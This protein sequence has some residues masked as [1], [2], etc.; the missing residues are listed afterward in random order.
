[1]TKKNKSIIGQSMTIV[2]EVRCGGELII[3][4]K[5]EGV[6]DGTTVVVGESGQ[7]IGNIAADEIECSGHVEG[8][9]VSDKFIVRKGGCHLGT[10]ETREIKVDPGATL[11]CVLQSG[12]PRI[13]EPSNPGIDFNRMLSVFDDRERSCTMD[14]PWS[15]RKKLLDQLL[16]LLE[17][18][19]QLIKIT[20]ENGSGKTTFIAKLA[21]S[22]PADITPITISGPVGSVREFLAIIAGALGV[23]VGVGGPL[24]EMVLQIKAA[25]NETGGAA[26]KIVLS[27]D[28]AHTMYPATIEGVI[29]CLTSACGEGEE[30]LQIILLGTDEIE[31]KLVHSA[32]E[33]FEDETNCILALEPLTVKDTAEYLR[34]CVQMA[35]NNNSQT[36]MTLFPHEAIEKLHLQS[37]GNIAEI[38]QLAEN[39]LRSSSEKV[40]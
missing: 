7:L 14:V 40:D 33:Y 13:I 36:C 39:L 38:N 15:E 29:R 28:D 37:R 24:P 21:E 12:A 8:N 3:D 30:L 11:D 5:I 25:L 19:K 6:L 23:S 35:S 34:F 10:V 16:H 2:G 1:M 31:E 18:G 26:K 9:I 4:G 17:R 22:L 27:I 20:G 32:K